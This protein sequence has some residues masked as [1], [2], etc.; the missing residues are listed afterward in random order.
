MLFG[1]TIEGFQ[2]IFGAWILYFQIME[3]RQVANNNVKEMLF[4]G[5]KT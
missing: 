2:E 5:E 4:S 3:M 1:K